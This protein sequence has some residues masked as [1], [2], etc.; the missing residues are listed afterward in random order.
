MSLESD[1]INTFD[2]RQEIPDKCAF[3][4]ALCQHMSELEGLQSRQQ[5]IQELYLAAIEDPELRDALNTRLSEILGEYGIDIEDSP[6]KVIDTSPMDQVNESADALSASEYE[7]IAKIRD[8]VAGC[9]S[10]ALLVQD[11]DDEGVEYDISLCTSPETYRLGSLHVPVHVERY[12]PNEPR[13]E[14]LAEIIRLA[15]MQAIDN[16]R[17]NN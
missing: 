4:P 13:Q 1:G 3:C 8:L 11:Q 5:V 2:A 12:D 7:L 16:R 10:G 14:S 17:K 15:L 9:R 6:F